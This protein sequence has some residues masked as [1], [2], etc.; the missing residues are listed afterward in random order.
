MKADRMGDSYVIFVDDACFD[1][2]DYE[3]GTEHDT[4][5]MIMT[6]ILMMVLKMILR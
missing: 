6:I 1:I 4:D 3:T 5:D 2:H